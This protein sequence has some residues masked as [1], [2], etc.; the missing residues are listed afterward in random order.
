M[1]RLKDFYVII[2]HMWQNAKDQKDAKTKEKKFIVKVYK[3]FKQKP[4]ILKPN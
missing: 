3:H 2:K 4:N 1:P